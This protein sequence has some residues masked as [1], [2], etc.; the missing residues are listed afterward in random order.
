MKH[1]H[2]VKLISLLL[3]L[4]LIVSMPAG[5]ASKTEQTSEPTSESSAE[6]QTEPIKFKHHVYNC[7]FEDT[8]GPEYH[9]AYDNL[10]DAVL[11]GRDWFECPD[12][13]T[14]DWVVG[15]IPYRCY[16]VIDEYVDFTA[17]PVRFK[18]GK[19][20]F[21]YK[22]P[23]DEFKVKLEEF[24]KII[25]DI[26][27]EAVRSDYTDFE[28][29]LALYGYVA[30]NYIYDYEKADRM[31]NTSDYKISAYYFFTQKTE[32]C[33]GISIAYSYLLMQLG[34]DASIVMGDNH[35]WSIVKYKDKYYHIDPTFAMTDNSSMAYFMMDDAQRQAEGGFDPARFTYFSVYTHDHPCGDKYR[36]TD[37][38]YNVLWKYQYVSLD[39]KAQTISCGIS[40][41]EENES[42]YTLDSSGF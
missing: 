2:A 41:G 17:V 34:I 13:K 1:L 21:S 37:D 8:F 33:Q 12:E 38:S 3:C 9:K 31:V 26:L 15:Q 35:Q 28:K 4:I 22:I 36:C 24:E 16:P 18:D 30:K 40:V 6:N 11:E 42:V 7:F 19:A 14:R 25:T 10:V 20:Y 39:H 23:Y 32:V 29:M 5:C 27:N